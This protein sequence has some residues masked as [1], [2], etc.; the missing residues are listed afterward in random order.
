MHERIRDGRGRSFRFRMHAIYELHYELLILMLSRT[1]AA[2]V[3]LMLLCSPI[4]VSAQAATDTAATDEVAMGDG[5]P[6]PAGTTDCF[7]YYSFGSVQAQ[8]TPSVANTVS[9]TPLTF[10]GTL[11]NANPYPIV[12]GALYVKIFK[13]RGDTNDG[14]GPDVVDQFLVK[15]GYVI[16]AKGAVPVS[17]SWTV[18]SYAESGEYSVATFFTT[19]HKF[20]LLGLSFTDDVV[21]NTVPF[22]VT[23]EQTTGVA[24]DKASATINGERSLFATPPL[25]EDAT[26]PVTVSAT[27]V[28]TTAHAQT[29]AVS[30]QVSQWDA[31]LRENVVQEKNDTIT[32]PAHGSAP[33]TIT[34]TDTKYPVYYAVATLGYQD[35]KSIVGIRFIR[36]GVD[37][38]R[39]NF[40]GVTSFPLKAGQPS[41]LFSCLHNAGQSDVV[42]G[43]SLDLLLTDRQGNLI[44]EYKYDGDVTGAMMGVAT[45]FTPTKDYDYFTL[46]ARLFQNG[47]FVDEADLTYDCQAIDP[48]ACGSGDTNPVPDFATFLLSMQNLMIVG[49]AIIVL[50][51]LF[52][53]YHRLT[54][55]PALPPQ[56]P[57]MPL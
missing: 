17:F 27:I 34:V 41:T 52:W 16:P 5:A 24:F 22:T 40:P 23:G 54:R 49:G 33:A 42:H 56:T 38:L 35:T 37:R 4:L 2:L 48:H 20:N 39:I 9:G 46:T 21:G 10:S 50:I 12:D 43:G 6:A 25:H 15:D 3:A 18:P 44:K 45:Q 57:Q 7:Q 36:D 13:K 53:M 30:W 8:L 14:N 19:S 1:S 32:V 28:N 31:Q 26:S 47:Q 55:K 29:V 11:K 51:L